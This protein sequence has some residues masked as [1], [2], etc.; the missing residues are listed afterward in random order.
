MM[1]DTPTSRS[2][3][4]PG[5]QVEQGKVKT[6]VQQVLPLERAA[7]GME[8]VRGGHVRGKVIIRVR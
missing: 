1:A 5:V 3:Q 2:F 7:E 8:L 4:P 6:E